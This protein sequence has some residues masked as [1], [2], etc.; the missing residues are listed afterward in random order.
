MK[1]V[2][3]AVDRNNVINSENRLGY[4]G[5]YGGASV[6]CIDNAKGVKNGA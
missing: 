1:R 4:C 2:N 3:K 6:F 5:Y